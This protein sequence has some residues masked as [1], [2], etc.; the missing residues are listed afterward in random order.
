MSDPIRTEADDEVIKAYW[1]RA[2]SKRDRKEMTD[3][4][5]L[6]A[7]RAAWGRRLVEF[8]RDVD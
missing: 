2:Q 4:L 6:K 5:V 7:E 1:E 8:A 3:G